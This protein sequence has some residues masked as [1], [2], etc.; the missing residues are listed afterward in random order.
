M[1]QQIMLTNQKT[2]EG[3]NM[4]KLTDKENKL[5]QVLLDNNDGT[6]CH[7]ISEK[8]FNEKRNN[9]YVSEHRQLGWSFTTLKGV[10]GSIIN[11]GL[12]TYDQTNEHGD[13]FKFYV[14]VSP[15]VTG[16]EE[17]SIKTPLDY[18]NKLQKKLIQERS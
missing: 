6:D 12:L 11:K 13:W 9:Q 17:Q 8:Y 2:N 10:L 16:E 5:M 14:G 3:E 1:V 7:C 18:V 4:I 15:E